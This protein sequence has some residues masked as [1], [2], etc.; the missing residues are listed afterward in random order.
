MK[1]IFLAEKLGTFSR[2][3][4]ERGHMKI[5]GNASLP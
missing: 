5:G 4:K 2:V 1:N 3:V